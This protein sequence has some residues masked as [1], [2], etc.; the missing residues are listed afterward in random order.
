M[1][2][3][4]IPVFQFGKNPSKWNSFSNISVTNKIIK[5]FNLNLYFFLGYKYAFIS[6][7]TR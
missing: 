5:F 6:I 4:T 7:N 1:L 2:Q 3:K